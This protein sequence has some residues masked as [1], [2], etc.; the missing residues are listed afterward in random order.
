MFVGLLEVRATLPPAQKVVTPPAL[1]DGV[2]GFVPVVRTRGAER[3]LGQLLPF[4]NCRV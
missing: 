4:V 1:M 3:A 2:A